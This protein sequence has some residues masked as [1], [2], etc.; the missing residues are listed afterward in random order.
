MIDRTV[1]IQIVKLPTGQKR[2][3][4]NSVRYAQPFQNKW[5]TMIDQIESGLF[6]DS[7][8]TGNVEIIESP[9]DILF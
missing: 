4:C 6:K 9:L 3:T 2:L 1:Y 8:G 5:S 7:C